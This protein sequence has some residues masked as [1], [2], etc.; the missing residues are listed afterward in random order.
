MKTLLFSHS[1]LPGKENE[2]NTIPAGGVCQNRLI[3]GSICG[4]HF[5]Q[6]LTA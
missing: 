5:E 4:R 1:S 2:R 6:H 3:G